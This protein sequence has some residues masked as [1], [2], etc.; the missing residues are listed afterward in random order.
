M[1][2]LERPRMTL[3]RMH[4]ACW[5]RKATNAHT[6]DVIIIA[7]PGQLWIHEC[8]SMLRYAYVA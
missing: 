4:I 1:V 6:A 8:P 2:Q 3:W 5:I 7:F